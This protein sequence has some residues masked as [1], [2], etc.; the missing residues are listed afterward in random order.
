MGFGGATG[1]SSFLAGLTS[2][3]QT[4]LNQQAEMQFREQQMA[5]QAQWNIISSALDKSPE[6]ANIPEFQAMLQQ[7]DLP[8]VIAF[9]GAKAKSQFD[10]QR[11]QQEAVSQQLQAPETLPGGEFQVPFEQIPPQRQAQLVNERMSALPLD[12]RAAVDPN[13]V[14]VDRANTARSAEAGRMTR[15]EM[16][17]ARS[18]RTYGLQEKEF[19]LKTQEAG[20]RRVGQ[21]LTIQRGQMKNEI[22]DGVP[23]I[24][25]EMTD[26]HTGE[27]WKEVV[28]ISDKAYR[29]PTQGQ[30]DKMANASKQLAYIADIEDQIRDPKVNELLGLK[31]EY[32]KLKLKE[33]LGRMN[34]KETELSATVGQ[35]RKDALFGD[36]GKVLT[37]TEKAIVNRTLP[38]IFQSPES[39]REYLRVARKAQMLNGWMT[40]RQFI[41]DRGYVSVPA[42]YQQEF[43][44]LKA[45]HPAR[46]LPQVGTRIEMPGSRKVGGGGTSEP[47]PTEEP[48]SAFNAIFGGP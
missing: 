16:T 15:A 33:F 8:G 27:R 45:E 46:S 48:Q 25:A 36:A 12:Q 14:K 17:Q 18:D 34:V 31:P 6:L 10:P 35:L 20:R 26:P 4:A 21:A 11:L 2:G 30:S 28:G 22:V 42:P 41:G 32:Y 7:H 40:E 19:G 44:Q 3:A 37:S 39:F 47:A 13:A 24:A 29:D 1:I 43:E 5:R 23:V 9:I 38:E